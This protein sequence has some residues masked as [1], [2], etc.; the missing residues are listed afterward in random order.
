LYLY[1][2]IKLNFLKQIREIIFILLLILSFSGLKSQNYYYDLYNSE[3]GLSQS[4]VFTMIQD[5]LGKIWFGTIGGGIDIYDGQK[6]N[7]LNTNSGLPNN[8][9]YKIFTDNKNRYWI[10]TND[11][12]ALYNGKTFKKFTTNEGLP[13]NLI[14][15][16]TQDK[17]GT[18]WVG[19]YSGAAKFVNGKFKRI[20]ENPILKEFKILK[21]F[22]DSKNRGWF[23]TER[24]GVV[25]LE[26]NKYTTYTKDNNLGNNTVRS[27]IEDKKGNIWLGNDH[28]MNIYHNN[29][30]YVY[31]KKMQQTFTSAAKDINGN[32]WFATYYGWLINYKIPEKF[33]SLSDYLTSNSSKMFNGFRFRAIFIDR[34]NNFWL[35]SNS[36]LVKI[37]PFPF[38]NFNSK[39]NIINNN[40]TYLLNVGDT[41]LYIGTD[42]GIS[43]LKPTHTDKAIIKNLSPR[44]TS[45][46]IY[47]MIADSDKIWIGSVSRLS[48]YYL[49]QKKFFTYVRELPSRKLSNINYIV[50]SNIVSSSIR[51][52]YKDRDNKIWYG[53]N[54]GIGIIDNN[55]FI[56]FNK[57]FPDITPKEV[58]YIT[59]D[60]KNNY[61]FCTATDGV[62]KYS[63]ETKQLNHFNEKNGITSSISKIVED[64]QHQL[65]FATRKGIYTME[66]DSFIQFNTK[67][68]LAS[69][70]IYSIYIDKNNILYIG[71]SKGID[72]INLTDYHNSHK[73]SVTHIS[74]K[75]G[76]IGQECNRNAVTLFKD[77]IWFGTVK[78]I[79]GFNPKEL[80]RNLVAPKV[81][82]TDVQIDFATFDWQHYVSKKTLTLPYNKNHLT[83]KFIATSFVNPKKV[84][85]R[86]KLVGLNENWSPPTSKTEQD[87]PV[88]PPGEYTFLVKAANNDGIWSKNNAYFT[89]VIEKPIYERWWFYTAVGFLILL[90]IYGYT[91]YRE[92]NL[93]KEKIKLEK[94]VK[95][96]TQEIVKQK[97]I[98]EQVNKDIT[99]SINYA[100]NIQE[101]LLPKPQEFKILPESF[102]LFKPRDIVSGDFYWVQQKN[103]ILYIAAADCTGHGVPGA[104][105]SMLGIAFLDE[106]LNKY[107]ELQASEILN[108]L[109]QNVIISLHQ[110]EEESKSKDGMDI[111]LCK[112]NFDK[113]TIEFAGANNPLY[114]IRDGEFKEFKGDK[115]PIGFHFKTDNFK[116]NLIEFKPNDRL[117]IFSD[118][119]ADQFGGPKGKKFKY[120][121]FKELLLKIHK[122]P[123][124]RQRIILYD[125]LAEWS[126]GYEQLDDILVIGIKL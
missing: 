117:Y 118:G 12:L 35:G 31:N 122:E 116:N 68:G 77:K 108:K 7:N 63:F 73:F 42:G 119:Y 78:G 76:F 46:S 33:D 25:K 14:F 19:T 82:I 48:V 91:K 50:D 102:V 34:E 101:A 104:F 69:D 60:F 20:D 110:T 23:G 39:D 54:L 79:T 47:S 84:K 98:V 81:I 105:M 123:M 4:Q 10:G 80:K 71:S 29:K 113:K 13:N 51:C 88:L 120:K 87:Y 8:I 56:N 59:Q 85:Y 55:K 99:D 94:I 107:D 62:Y 109:R 66:A 95:E 28:C 49:Y 44:K 5:S 106:I 92:S 114:L 75:E 115:M 93:K 111:A 100:K 37:P 112:I 90:I 36:G 1:K 43:I 40:I 15:D 16:I 58:L 67:R 89:F 18:I 32:I 126:K 74:S 3:N 24:H 45:S 86:Y 30:L 83:F 9:V 61:W 22:F 70:Y 26:N 41:N 27:I 53:T 121:K 52:F 6:F 57:Q 11:G 125:T 21:V 17:T 96:R 97:E 64:K 65:W 103:N 124:F 2:L 72:Y 38:I